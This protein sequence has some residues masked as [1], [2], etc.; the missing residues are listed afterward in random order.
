M[1]RQV[2]LDNLEENKQRRNFSI[3]KFAACQYG[4]QE[5]NSKSGTRQI[6]YKGVEG[7]LIKN[8]LEPGKRIFHDQC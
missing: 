2:W 8:Q 3:P 5:G 1:G 6:N 4:N 7:Y